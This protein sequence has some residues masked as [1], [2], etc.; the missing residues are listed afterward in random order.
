[1]NHDTEW[2]FSQTQCHLCVIIASHPCVTE[3][4]K[5]A[6]FFSTLY[7]PSNLRLSGFSK[8]LLA[9]SC[10]TVPL[11]K[12]PLHLYHLV[13]ENPTTVHITQLPLVNNIWEVSQCLRDHGADTLISCY[14][15]LHLVAVDIS[16]LIT[17]D[18]FGQIAPKWDKSGDSFFFSDRIQ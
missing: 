1:M 8:Q 9:R 10:A 15:I 6:A 4:W 3:V 14:L 2:S 17:D 12:S 5:L 18:R 7:I 13:V 16:K 11:T